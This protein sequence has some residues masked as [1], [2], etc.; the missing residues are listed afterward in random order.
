MVQSDV[1]D[2]GTGLG[3]GYIVS[4]HAVT[5]SVQIVQA[6]RRSNV[7]DLLQSY[8]ALG[9]LARARCLDTELPW[10]L[11]VANRAQLSVEMI[12]SNPELT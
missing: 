3:S 2:D 1:Q 9:M 11:A 10:H 4:Q 8:Y 12:M 5:L 6:T 7:G